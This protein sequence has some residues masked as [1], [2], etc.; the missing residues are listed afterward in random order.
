MKQLLLYFS[1][2]INH[3]YGQMNMHGEVFNKNE[4]IPFATIEI[5]ELGRITKADELGLFTFVDIPYNTYTIK[6]QSHEFGIIIQEITFNGDKIHIDIGNHLQAL[7][8]VVVSGTL[9]EVSKKESVVNVEVYRSNFFEKNPTP[10][11]FESLQ[12][13]NGI[14]PQLNCNI[15]NTGDIHING[16]EGP[17]TTILIDGMPIVSSL[18][19]VYGLSGIPNSLVDRI[20]VIKGASSTLFGSEAIG[21]VVNIITKTPLNAPTLDVDL[22]STSWFE[23]NLDLTNSIKL[24]NR[25]NVLTGVN[26]YY[27]S[28]PQ[29]K[30]ADG[31]TDVTLQ[32]RISIFQKWVVNQKQRNNLSFAG[33]FIHEDRWGGQMNWNQ[34]Y[35]GSSDVYGESIYTTRWEIIAQYQLPI[36]ERILFNFSF[37]DHQQNSYYGDIPFMAKQTTGFA[38][39]LWDKRI[40]K[41]SM[42][43]GATFKSIFYDDNT[44]ATS[45]TD[46]IHKINTLPGVFIQDDWSIKMKVKI[47]AGIRY[48]YHNDHGNIF[49]PR[50][51]VL[52]KYNDNGSFR[53]NAGTGYRVVNIFSEDHAALTG[54]RK[55]ELANNLK[56]EDSYNIN[57]NWNHQL[58]TNKLVYLNFD[59]N[60]FYTHFSNRIIPDYEKN[61]NLI[62]Y[63]NLQGYAVS[64]GGNANIHVKFPFELE[65]RLGTTILDASIYGIHGKRSQMLTE[66]FSGNWIVSYKNRATGITLDYSGNIYSPMKLPLQGENDPRPE[67]SPWW[68]IQNIKLSFNRKAWTVYSGVKNLLNWTPSKHAPFL[69]ARSEDPFDNN[70]TF[71]NDGNAIATSE[72]PYGLTFDPSYV[73]APNQG[74]RFYLGLNYTL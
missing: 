27:Y 61:P 55:V 70:V 62:Y 39:A 22:F 34:L 45:E 9:K 54:G 28:L 30:N 17:Y 64:Q 65:V 11:I 36:K 66:K 5:I 43:G 49:S 69:I 32:N 56:P 18:S 16:F 12:N 29:D 67:S 31:F 51:G 72:N 13:I 50:F 73:Y 24:G 14:R 33:R 52:Y 41:H 42:M 47:L 25:I 2:M 19:T 63:D 4:S 40:K 6:L 46:N 38:Q 37:N 10:N 26:Y 21:G 60:L 3:C 58:I 74:I 53:L 57:I 59:L 44:T 20:E 23:N 35:R 7:D 68:S 15:C 48:D 71:D 1:L 8:E